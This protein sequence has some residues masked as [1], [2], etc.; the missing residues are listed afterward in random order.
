MFGL[1]KEAW[2]DS[3][4]QVLRDD[5]NDILLRVPLLSKNNVSIMQ[6][7]IVK[8]VSHIEGKYGSL[9]NIP[10][11]LRIRVAKTLVEEARTLYDVNTGKGYGL[12][13]VSMFL[14][15]SVLPGDAAQWVY[16]KTSETINHALK[17]YAL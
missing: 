1:M 4:G 11:D 10:R 9:S 3:R 6:E 17:A 16:T 13:Y 15:S 5:L 12:C 8:E 2:R 14:E 7:T